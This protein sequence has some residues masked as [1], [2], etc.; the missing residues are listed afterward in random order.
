MLQLCKVT[1]SLF[2]SNARSAC[3]DEL[4]QKEAVTLCIN[5]SQQQPCPASDR[6]STLRVPAYDDPNEDLH[7][8]FDR[9]ADIILDEEARGGRTVVYCKN[10][11]SRS[12]TICIAYLMK[13]QCLSLTEAY[14]VV[15][16]ARSVAEPNQG[17]WAQLERYEQ[18]LQG[19]R[20]TPEHKSFSTA[21]ISAK[22]CATKEIQRIIN[23]I[24]GPDHK[25][26]YTKI[27]VFGGKLRL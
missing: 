14:E 6:I 9:C 24:I 23:G 13:H 17:F 16:S 20:A 5:V 1:H 8:H 15:K 10:G 18:E 25:F 7:S 21:T 19:K 11:R 4:L 2:I 27:S 3:N 26:L 12:A 22:T